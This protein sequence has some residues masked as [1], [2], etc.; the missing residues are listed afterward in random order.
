MSA[1][2]LALYE[3]PKRC[4]VSSYGRVKLEPKW[5][6]LVTHGIMPF[7]GNLSLMDKDKGVIQGVQ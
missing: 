7:E 2:H 1:G 3:W 4:H 6:S 5:S